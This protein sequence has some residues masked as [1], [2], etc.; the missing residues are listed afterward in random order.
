M[1]LR[2]PTTVLT[3]YS[4]AKGGDTICPQGYGKIRRDKKR[5]G[6]ERWLSGHNRSDCFQRP[7]VWF[8]EPMFAV[9]SDL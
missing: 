6:L 1:T 4:V 9:Y 7:S 8:L 3:S 2:S 5:E